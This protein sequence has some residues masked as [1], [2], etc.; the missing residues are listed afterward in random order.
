M[1]RLQLKRGRGQGVI[2]EITEPAVPCA[3]LCNLEFINS[4]LLE[5][6][7]RIEK[8]QAFVEKLGIDDGFRGWYAKVI[9]EGT[10]RPG[11]SVALV[12]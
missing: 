1:A 2:V 4:R 11:D 3:N 5:P 8:C 12:G 7:Q 10:I 9:S 6:R